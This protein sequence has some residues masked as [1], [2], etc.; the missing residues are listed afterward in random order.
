MR[1]ECGFARTEGF[2]SVAAGLGRGLSD[3]IRL[4]A[5]HA[6]VSLPLVDHPHQN[7]QRDSVGHAQGG[8]EG[9]GLRCAAQHWVQNASEAR[10]RRACAHGLR[11][12]GGQ[13]S[14]PS[15]H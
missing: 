2:L 3:A 12:V 14:D 8:A 5:K 15:P 7:S 1:A 11:G 9:A 4:N 10:R 13:G 6:S